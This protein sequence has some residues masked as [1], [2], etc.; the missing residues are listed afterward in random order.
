MVITAIHNPPEDEIVSTDKFIVNNIIPIAIKHIQDDRFLFLF[1][2]GQ[3]CVDKYLYLQML[4]TANNETENIQLDT[5]HMN[6][7]NIMKDENKQKTYL[8]ATKQLSENGLFTTDFNMSESDKYPG[9]YESFAMRKSFESKDKEYFITRTLY[10]PRGNYIR[11]RLFLNFNYLDQYGI[12]YCFGEKRF[13]TIEYVNIEKVVHDATTRDNDNN[14]S[15]YT[16]WCGPSVFKMNVITPVD[17]KHKDA[18][19][20]NPLDKGL[21][22]AFYSEHTYINDVI[23]EGYK[24]GIVYDDPDSHKIRLL[25]LDERLYRKTNFKNINNYIYEEN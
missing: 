8:E 23:I 9:Y 4:V 21:Y 25:L 16:M 13:D 19:L 17:D 20:A 14:V 7:S 1:L 6:L 24:V 10:I 12:N 18:K 11:L 2:A 3:D 15:H 22:D 5:H